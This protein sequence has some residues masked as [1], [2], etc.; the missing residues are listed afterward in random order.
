MGC[1]DPGRL[2]GCQSR[3]L[4]STFRRSWV[5]I[6]DIRPMRLLTVL[7]PYC[8]L[9]GRFD[10]ATRNFWVAGDTAKTALKAWF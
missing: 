7:L 1:L 3:R 9:Y 5:S 2:G 8:R 6:D 4:E 10:P